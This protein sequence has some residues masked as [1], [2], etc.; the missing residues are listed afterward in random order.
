MTTSPQATPRSDA[1]PTHQLRVRDVDG[2]AR[3]VQIRAPSMAEAVR[4]ATA[5]GLQVLAT[6]GGASTGIGADA[7]AALSLAWRGRFDVSL[8]SQELLALLD[9]G[10]NVT[11]AIDALHA[12]ERRPA[13]RVV[14]ERMRAALQ[15]G[16]SLSEA[17]SVQ[18]K[19]FGDIYVATV[20][21]SER[22]G[23]LGEALARYVAYELQFDAVRRKLISAS[24]YPAML[25]LV[26]LFV[27]LFLLGYVVPSFSAMFDETSR[28]VPW[29]SAQL[30]RAGQAIHAHWGLATALIAVAFAAVV[31]VALHPV[32]RAALVEWVLRAPGIA[33][34]VAQFRHARLFRAL[35]LLLSSGVPLT[36][37]LGMVGGLLGPEQL[38]ALS[39]VRLDV[40]EGHP[41]SAAL[42]AAGLSDPVSDSLLRVG[43][44]SGQLSAM[45]DRAAR[46][47]DEAFTRWMD[48][49]S[50]LLEPMLMVAIGGVIGTVVV[51]MYM[52]IFA[53]AGG[54]P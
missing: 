8:F 24:I 20:H 12:K 50:R 45:L 48:W 15:E 39:R 36:Q 43:E 32:S 29:L 38:A 46:F 35:G 53:L 26:G 3:D 25:S 34:R 51:L 2:R 49:A 16:R 42:L 30:M 19:V 28:D 22:T 18:P 11:E 52:P 17:L 54:L 6:G 40:N 27:T 5:R 47:G 33:A 7:K 14:F 37:A 21:A 13:A 10:L 23:N 44:R 41:L 4:R 1:H 31:I 9:A